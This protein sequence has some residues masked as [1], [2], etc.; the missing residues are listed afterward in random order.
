MAMKD[1]LISD[2]AIEMY[3]KGLSYDN[4]CPYVDAI[5]KQSCSHCRMYFGSI[6][7]KTFH[8][9]ACKT[10][11]SP[12]EKQRVKPQRIAARQQR[13]LLCVIEMQENE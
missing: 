11:A 8:Q 5:K 7:R 12:L 3:P 1:N 9:A 10:V 13:K 6:C 2:V 4:S